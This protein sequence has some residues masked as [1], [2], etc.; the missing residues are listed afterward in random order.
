[1]DPWYS[2]VSDGKLRQGEILLHMPVYLP[3]TY[4]QNPA[5]DSEQE[6]VASITDVILITPSCDLV[7]RPLVVLCEHWD[8][9]E[10]LKAGLLNQSAIE[11]I[12]K[13]RRPLSYI[14]PASPYPDI[15]LG[16]RIIDFSRIYSLPREVVLTHAQTQGPRLRLLPPYC[17]HFAQAF[18]RC[19]MRIGLPNT[20][21]EYSAHIASP[22]SRSV[23]PLPREATPEPPLRS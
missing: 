22:A 18:G 6:A 17:E 21:S 23:A 15:P 1:M 11:E 2:L 14:L 4:V 7:R 20:A 5:K 10:Q 3:T 12:E 9:A 16:R 19:Y 13:G 8:L